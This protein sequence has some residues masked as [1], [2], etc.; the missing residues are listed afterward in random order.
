VWGCGVTPYVRH[1][2]DC[3][4]CD[5]G[6]LRFYYCFSS[7]SRIILAIVANAGTAGFR[8]FGKNAMVPRI[9]Y[10]SLCLYPERV[11][12]FIPVEVLQNQGND[13]VEVKFLIFQ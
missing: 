2:T 13:G 6:H 4:F 10:V 5:F 11:A 8:A 7:L 1:S 12:Q 3:T 9:L